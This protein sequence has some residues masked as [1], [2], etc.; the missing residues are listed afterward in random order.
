MYSHW[1]DPVVYWS[2]RII[3]FIVL[4]FCGYCISHKNAGNKKYW[5]YSSLAIVV[6]SLNYGLR[7]NRSFDYLHYYS[8]LTSDTLWTSYDEPVYLLWLDFFKLSGLPYWVA[9]IF[10]SFI[11]IYGF[12]LILKKFP[13]AAVWA[14][15]LF[16]TLPS[17][18]DNFV[19]QFFATA[20]LFIGVSCLLDRS[21][22]KCAIAFLIATM[23]HL[24]ALFG[25]F[26]VVFAYL[27]KFEKTIK[28]PW[29]IIFVYVGLY[30]LWDVSYL[31]S[32]ASQ[33]TFLNIGENRMQ[34]YLDNADAWF[35]AEGDIN[36]RLGVAGVGRFSA[37]S[38][39]IG[40]LISVGII[41]YGH[42]LL[43]LSKGVNVVY[44]TSILAMFIK[45]IG[46]SIEI[47]SRFYCWLICFETILIGVILYSL[48]MRKIERYVAICMCVLY[49]Y[50]IGFLWGMTK[51]S[52]TGY[53]FIWD[54]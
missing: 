54:R 32:F 19:R 2:F 37:V 27:F 33:L 29:V 21:I 1:G 31:D 48:R 38:S 23:I 41:Y 45:I 4:F 12:L 28:S 17:N 40:M 39:F 16:F 22:K 30:F 46:G 34:N 51:V 13:Y 20:F 24:S 10:Y 5:F 49:Y 14:L 53:A 43:N 3:T 26:C 11:L 7:W 9:F 36:K 35:S 50:G 6:Y 8:D 15:P 18:V 44:W 47:Y 42:K 52:M 25:I